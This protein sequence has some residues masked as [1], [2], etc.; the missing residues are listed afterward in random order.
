MFIATKTI[1]SALAENVMKHVAKICTRKVGVERLICNSM[2]IEDA[3][4]E[5][6]S[7]ERE[8]DPVGMT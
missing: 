4:H 1:A 8:F 7:R 3:M 6:M 2:N 5:D